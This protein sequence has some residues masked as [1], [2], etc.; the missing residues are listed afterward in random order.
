[1][2]RA[3]RWLRRVVALA[4]TV[5]VCPRRAL[6]A[7]LISASLLGCAAA[8][9]PQ[10]P[11]EDGWRYAYVMQSGHRGTSMK[12]PFRDCRSHQEADKFGDFVLASYKDGSARRH[13]ISPMENIEGLKPGDTVFVNLKKCWEPAVRQA[14]DSMGS[15]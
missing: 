1:M 9:P 15:R 6:F 13:I 10:F 14:P 3:A 8:Y 5:Y 2:V 12:K 11:W 4:R 7:V